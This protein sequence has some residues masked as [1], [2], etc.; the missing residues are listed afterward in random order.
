MAP[1]SRESAERA[2]G[3]LLATGLP[4][5]AKEAESA[6]RALNAQRS[7][8]V[9]QQRLIVVVTDP[10]EF[11]VAQRY[12]GDVMSTALF[13][14]DVPLEPRS[15][16]EERARTEYFTA[17]RSELSR[18]DLRGFM[19]SE[20]E[21]SAFEVDDLYQ[22][23]K[24]TLRHSVLT[25]VPL[26]RGPESDA[27]TPVL[28]EVVTGDRFAVIVGRPGSGK[29]FLLRHDALEASRQQKWLGF[30]Q[31]LPILLSLSAYARSPRPMTLLMFIEYWLLRQNKAIGHLLRQ[32][33]E[34]GSVVLLLDGLDEV[35]DAAEVGRMQKAIF[36]ALTEFPRL[37][38]VAT[39]RPGGEQG[40]LEQATVFDVAPFDDN[41]IGAFLTR[42]SERYALAREGPAAGTGGRG[43][44]AALA[45][46]VISHEH[47]HQLATNPLMLTVLAI[48]HRAGVRLPGHRVQLYAQAATILVEK[49]NQ[50]RSYDRARRVRPVEMTDAVR[51]LGPVA[52]GIVGER[53][54]GAIPEGTL[55][56]HLNAALPRGKIE[57]IVSARDALTL[58]GDHLGLF[59]ET[60]SGM[61]AFAHLTLAEYFAAWE[62]V[63]TNELEDWAERPDIAFDP[64][65]REVMLFA[66]GILGRI[67]GDDVRLHDL[68][69]RFLK[70]QARVQSRTELD[71]AGLFSGLLA[72][73]VALKAEDTRRLSEVLLAVPNVEL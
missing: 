58:F 55:V 50:I 16:D 19:R 17:L 63:R 3:T 36:A 18:F 40:T 48:V 62:L 9:L 65:W 51:L 52:L 21:D 41:A 27:I 53:A 68:V 57:G 67:R 28:Q 54:R 49:W 23:L 59:I 64:R 60:A 15:V 38:V 42:W 31:P 45:A 11:D 4:E 10:W 43:A 12:A 26:R 70:A 14:A 72:D 33:A 47:V 20:T 66:A 56:R 61:W 13:V 30:E 29:S 35:G 46:E 2:T 32:T 6:L 37:F 73:D 71:V 34:R 25:K 69:T 22:E 39:T 5:D 1:L 44:G 8:A 24:G 7:Q